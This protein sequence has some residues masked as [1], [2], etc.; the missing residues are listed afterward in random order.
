MKPKTI[1]TYTFIVTAMLL[2][3]S[4]IVS[5]DLSNIDFESYSN[6]TINNQDGWSSFGAAGSGC[7]VY[8]HAVVDNTYGYASFGS[9]SLRISNAVTSGCFGDQTFS[10]SL[11]DEAGESTAGNGGFSGGTRHASF[12]AQW[13]FASTKP[14]EEQ[15]GLSVV[16]S[17]DRGDGAR[18]SWIQMADTPSGLEVNF[19]DYQTAVPDFIFTNVASGLDRT[20]PHT[21]RI[22]MEFVEGTANDIVRVY[23]D[24]VLG[25]TGTSWEDYFRDVE[26]NPTRTV[27][28]ILFRTAG[29][30]APGTAGYGFLIDNLTLET[31]APPPAASCD[32]NAP[33]VNVIHGTPKNDKIKGTPGNDIIIGYGGNDRLEGMGGNDCLIGGPGDDQLYGDEGGDILWGGEVDNSTVYT[34]KDRDKLYGDDGDDE[35]YGGGDK[36]RL[37]GNDGDDWLYGDDGDDTMVGHDGND[38]MYGG[39]GRD[40]M[41]GDDGND[42]I[43]GE[44]GDDKLYG[45]Q[46]DD[47]LDGGDNNDQLDGS[48]GTD[49]CIAGEKLK[50]CEQ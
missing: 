34:S 9:R 13:D 7:A 26:G 17:P 18:M 44:A 43:Y 39:A 46:G 1:L 35:L 47:T 27:D 8:D 10:K 41:R 29:T 24:G 32:L 48:A 22:E 30:A 20:I 31:P 14:N 4:S 15:T 6:G 5:A 45:R 36:D 28:S 11:A 33:N 25:H 2:A 16:A 37:D 21:I 3:L 40:N 38:T 49:T 50:S 42:M 23:V 19:Y 12:A